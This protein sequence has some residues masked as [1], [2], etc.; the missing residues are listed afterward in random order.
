LL[1]LDNHETLFEVRRPYGCFTSLSL[2]RDGRRLAAAWTAH[3]TGTNEGRVLVWNFPGGEELAEL[4][5]CFGE[6]A[7]AAFHPDG[8]RIAATCATGQTARE[9]A[10]HLWQL[11]RGLEVLR[12][13][14]TGVV[15][16]FS[17]DGQW[18]AS[19]LGGEILFHDAA[20]G[21]P[22]RGLQ[23]HKAPVRALAFSP[24]GQR[25]ASVGGVYPTKPEE[26]QPGE[27]KLW[28]L[29]T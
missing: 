28:D 1:R 4:K 13:V 26:K 9:T 10:L 15:V 3:H 21:E 16:N 20:T 12:L 5:P 22:L 17:P 23:G 6:V 29:A 18:L 27:V 25:L 2:S 11:P 24:D 19:A 7:A 14:E 8:E